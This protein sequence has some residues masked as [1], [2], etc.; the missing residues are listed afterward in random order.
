MKAPCSGILLALVVFLAELP[1]SLQLECYICQAQED[2]KGK[3]A[4]TVKTCD[5]SQDQCLTEVRW[6]SVPHWA[7]T[8]KKQYYISKKCA[9]KS[10]CRD[11]ITDSQQKCDRIW[12]NDWNCT[13]CCSGDKCNYFV[14]LAGGTVQPTNL[15]LMLLGQ[16][17]AAILYKTNNVY[18][19][20][21]LQT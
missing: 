21:T 15:V 11:A 2:N 9:T 14:T 7:L 12:F 5:L 3:C 6:G 18:M 16:L 4:E 10:E 1:K 8:S 19:T 17:V 20:R 13:S